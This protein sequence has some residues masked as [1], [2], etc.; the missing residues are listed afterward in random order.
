M[1]TQND[2]HFATTH[3]KKSYTIN[4]FRIVTMG[5]GMKWRKMLK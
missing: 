5:K 1:F 4:T 3:G 2:V